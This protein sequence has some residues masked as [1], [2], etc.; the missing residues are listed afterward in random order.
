LRPVLDEIKDDEA[1]HLARA[2]MASDMALV[3]QSIAGRASLAVRVAITIERNFGALQSS[4]FL[5]FCRDNAV[6]I[7]VR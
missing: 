7:D 1:D 2:F 5:A 3:I 6:L 4:S